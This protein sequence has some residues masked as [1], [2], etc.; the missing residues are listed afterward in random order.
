MTQGP[1][2]NESSVSTHRGA[3]WVRQRL[4][5]FAVWSLA[6]GMFLV[7]NRERAAHTYAVGII[8]IDQTV[9]SPLVDGTVRSIRVDRFDTISEGDILAMM[10]DTLILAELAIEEAKLGQIQAEIDVE[11]RRME[12]DSEKEAVEELDTLRRFRLDEE[13]AHLAHLELSVEVEADRVKLERLKIEMERQGNLVTEAI[14]DVSTY[15]DVRLRHEELR[16]ELASKAETLHIAK[17]NADIA[18]ERREQRESQLSEPTRNSLVYIEPL[19]QALNVQEARREEIQKERLALML[20][21]PVSGQIA[22][23]HFG[24]G[25]TVLSGTPLITIQGTDARRVVAYVDENSATSIEAGSEVQV[26]SKARP[27]IAVQARVLR[28]GTVLEE[29]PQRLWSSPVFAQWG[30]PVL[31]GEI[32]PDAFLPGETVNVRF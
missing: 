24:P 21:A 2:R 3:R 23:V 9:L 19:L 10:D 22:Q 5:P 7:L 20:R 15:D 1:L 30:Y 16:K 18:T 11:R 31:I 25:E 13:E 12:S 26:R 27:Q 6:I 28:A 14:G 4:V 32:P 29:L 17:R 8:E